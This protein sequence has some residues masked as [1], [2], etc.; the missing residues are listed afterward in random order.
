MQKKDDYI[1]PGGGYSPLLWAFASPALPKRKKGRRWRPLPAPERS[2]RLYVL[3]DPGKVH[4][5]RFFL[6]TEENL[7]LM[8]VVD[9]WRAALLVR[10]SPWQEREMRAFLESLRELLDLRII[11]PPLGRDPSAKQY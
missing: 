1:Q 11:E 10:F 8:T 4:L 9:R 5:F 3:I 2:S 7:G 6:E